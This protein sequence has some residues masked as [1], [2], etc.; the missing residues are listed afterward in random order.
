M[1]INNLRECRLSEEKKEAF[2]RSLT[3]SRRRVRRM[4]EEQE[5]ARRTTRR[6]R[7]TTRRA[8]RRAPKR[9]APRA[10]PGRRGRRLGGRRGKDCRGQQGDTGEFNRPRRRKEGQEGSAKRWT[11]LPVQ[12]HGQG[13]Q[14]DSVIKNS[15]RRRKEVN[16]RARLDQGDRLEEDAAWR[17]R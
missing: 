6:T 7:R 9:R 8:T 3:H 15:R 2:K 14:A 12:T 1:D 5:E 4:E 17:R 16:Q 10:L 11:E 13:A